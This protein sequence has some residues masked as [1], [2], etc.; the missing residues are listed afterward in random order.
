ME[1]VPWGVLWEEGLFLQP[2][3]L[4]QLSLG[5]TALTARHNEYSALHRWGVVTMDI[6]P[7]QLEQGQFELRKLEMVLRSGEIVLFRGGEG[8][9]ARVQTREIPAVAESK[10]RVYAGVRRLREHEPNV[11]EPGEDEFDPPRYI[12]ATTTVS[13]LTTGRNLVDVHLQEFNV[14]VFFE[15][16]RMDGFECIAITELV[17]PAVGLPLTRLSTE[18]APASV[19]LS[20]SSALH[21]PVKEIYAEAA[22]KAAELSGAATVADVIA[23]N[24]TE[25]ELVQ[26]WKLYTLRG[27]LPQLREAADNGLLHPFEVYQHLCRLL[28]QFSTLSEG[29]AAP[30]VPAYDHTD[31]GNCYEQVSKALLGLL[32]ADQ[33]AANF[34]RIPLARVKLPFAGLGMGARGLDPEWLRGQN[35]F[36]LVF[37]NPDS[38]GRE[39]DWYRSGHLKVAS[40][41]RISNT[42][43]QRKYGVPLTPCQKPRALPARDGAVYYRMETRGARPEMQAEW[44]AVC[45]ERTF[46]IHVATE[47]LAAGGPVPDLGME[48][49]VVFGR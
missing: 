1:N 26:L 44:E 15:G 35:I 28:G 17:A 12:R 3:H 20:A 21:M 45:R 25:A 18:F 29:A 32:R 34:K 30:S 40:F 9:N 19:L 22:G 8:G 24:A 10:L 39:R 48:A 43:A 14:R 41:Q 16:D 38:A 36:Y 7:L 42:V 46:V 4:Q 37:N 31:A 47:G 23:G 11:R 13:D 27:A 49:Y 2:H 6:D 33:L 5:S